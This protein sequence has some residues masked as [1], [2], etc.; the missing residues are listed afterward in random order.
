[1]LAVFIFGMCGSGKTTFSNAFKS[2]SFSVFHGGEELR[3]YMKDI[4]EDY[5]EYEKLERLT[6]NGLPLPLHYIQLFVE[7]HKLNYI[8]NNLI[9]DGY[10]RDSLQFQ[11]IP[12]LLNQYSSDWNWQVKGV[13]LRIS[14]E[15]AMRRCYFR[16]NARIDDNNKDII[17]ARINSYYV[18]TRPALDFFS[19]KYPLLQLDGCSTTIEQVTEVY[20]WIR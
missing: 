6:A 8:Q 1:M 7:S 5:N 15:I 14:P 10:P 11:Y 16:D 13:E 12:E 18:N 3:K 9:F 19:G 20:K 2:D 4:N 17:R